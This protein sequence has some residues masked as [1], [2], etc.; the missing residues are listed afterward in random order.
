MAATPAKTEE[1]KTIFVRRKK[2]ICNNFARGKKF[3]D[4]LN[5]I[6]G[7]PGA[8]FTKETIALR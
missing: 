6:R 3:Y 5:E 1:V 7:L 8:L 4:F 2:T